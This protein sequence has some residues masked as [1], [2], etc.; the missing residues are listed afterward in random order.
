MNKAVIFR[1]LN[2]GQILK[3][4]CIGQGVEVDNAILGMLFDPMNLA[5]PVANIF[6]TI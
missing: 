1:F 2:S 6:L 4:A 3:I 5:P